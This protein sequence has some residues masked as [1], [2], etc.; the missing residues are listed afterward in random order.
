MQ[1]SIGATLRWSGPSLWLVAAVSAAVVATDLAFLATDR[2]TVWREYVLAA[3]VVLMVVELATYR[4]DGA[5][6]GLRMSP[7]QGWAYWAKATILLGLVMLLV[8]SAAFGIVV[9]LL[10][11]RFPPGTITLRA[12]RCGHCSSGCASKC[13][14]LRRPFIGWRS[15]RPS[16]PGWDRGLPLPLAACFLLPPMCWGET[17][18]PITCLRALFWRGPF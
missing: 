1:T 2:L 13:R 10:D 17:P 8:L 3:I 11:I 7:L 9:G 15:A 18:P 16:L 14:W 6:F 12:R 5:L 4:G